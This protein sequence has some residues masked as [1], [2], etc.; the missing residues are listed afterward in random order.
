MEDAA[1]GTDKEAIE[2]KTNDLAQASH[3]LAEK[4]YQAE[5]A[6]GP[7]G[8]TGAEPGAAAGKADEDVVDAEFTEVKDK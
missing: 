5:Q 8:G 1:R 2:A 4:M 7:A 3:K 6:K